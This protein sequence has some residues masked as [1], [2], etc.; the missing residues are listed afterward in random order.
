MTLIIA[1]AQ[2]TSIAG[3]IESNVANHLRFGTIAAEH[4]AQLVVFPEL[5]LTGYEPGIARS[6]AICPE[7]LVLG[8]LRCLAQEAHIKKLI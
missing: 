5:S 8:S 6:S 7:A 3:K 2:S 4:G 1:A